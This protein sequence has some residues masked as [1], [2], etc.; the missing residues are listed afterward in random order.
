MRYGITIKNEVAAIDLSDGWTPEELEEART[1]LNS[2][3]DSHMRSIKERKAESE[4]KFARIKW[5]IEKEPLSLQLDMIAN[6]LFES[7]EDK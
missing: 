2:A 4:E 7:V 6:V 1:F 3:I 5:I